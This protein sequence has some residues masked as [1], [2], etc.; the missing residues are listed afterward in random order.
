MLTVADTLPI[1]VPGRL[2]TVLPCKHCSVHENVREAPVLGRY[3]A[4]VTV[5][6]E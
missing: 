4:S 6:E 2:A 3:M 5:F 1:E